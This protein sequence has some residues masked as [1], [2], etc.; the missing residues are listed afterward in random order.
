MENALNALFEYAP[1]EYEDRG[2]GWAHAELLEL[3]DFGQGDYAYDFKL[4]DGPFTGEIVRGLTTDNKFF[5][6][7]EFGQTFVVEYELEL[8]EHAGTSDGQPVRYTDRIYRNVRITGGP[9]PPETNE[10]TPGW[11]KFMNSGDDNE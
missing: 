8:D 10:L 4:L 7:D 5:E 9:I 1:F 6:K 3:L 11:T 2:Y